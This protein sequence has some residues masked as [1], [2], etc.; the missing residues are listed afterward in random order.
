MTACRCP[1]SSRGQ[2]SDARLQSPPRVGQFPSPVDGETLSESA[3]DGQWV[4]TNDRS[5]RK[6]AGEDGWRAN[7]CSNRRPFDKAVSGTPLA[8][9]ADA[10]AMV[11]AGRTAERQMLSEPISPTRLRPSLGL[12]S[13][14][15]VRCRR[16]GPEPLQDPGRRLRGHRIRH[17]L[18]LVKYRRRTVRR[19]PQDPWTEPFQR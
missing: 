3:R 6:C 4:P 15:L 18:W 17:G 14:V 1:G 9:A 19:R 5:Y 8:F 10:A 16:L 2:R 12:V 13:P 7:E 11:G